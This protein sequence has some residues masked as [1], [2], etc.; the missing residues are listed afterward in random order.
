MAVQMADLRA[1]QK[2][3]K[4]AGTVF[5]SSALRQQQWEVHDQISDRERYAKSI[6]SGD[7]KA[8]NQYAKRVTTQT[9]RRLKA[10]ARAQQEVV[11]SM[12]QLGES[13][14]RMQS[15]PKSL[16]ATPH[17][18]QVRQ[19][20][21]DMYGTTPAAAQRVEQRLAQLEQINPRQLAQKQ[22]RQLA[23]R[24]EDLDAA[25]KRLLSSLAAANFAQMMVALN[26]KKPP[27]ATPDVKAAQEQKRIA[28]SYAGLQKEIA[29]AAWPQVVARAELLVQRSLDTAKRA[30]LGMA[31]T[32]ASAGAAASQA[33]L[34]SATLVRLSMQAYTLGLW[35][36]WLAGW[37]GCTKVATA[38]QS[39]AQKLKPSSQCTWPQGHDVEGTVLNVK[40]EHRNGHAVSLAHVK[41]PQGVV[42]I[43]LPFIKLDSTGIVPGAV[44]SVRCSPARTVAWYPDQK[45]HQVLRFA[46]E[47]SAKTH[48]ADWLAL[49]A[50]D[51]FASHPNGLAAQWSLRPGS[52]GAAN[53]L[54]YGVWTDRRIFD[55]RIYGGL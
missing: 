16:R 44:V 40:I 25:A 36:H 32:P 1:L 53:V 29:R 14:T 8:V 51:L 20:L 26:A 2:S 7:W 5:V 41:S 39:A 35:V 18:Q 17:W 9:Q 12:Q 52:N 28:Q 50:Q 31:R 34:R 6:G 45:V 23:T 38:W 3:V 22:Q 47:K 33:A 13:I 49:H 27:P 24:A 55:R 43:G 46:T 19:G 37:Q 10:L 42:L 21:L 11:T 48:W 54:R 4:K 15:L 30:V